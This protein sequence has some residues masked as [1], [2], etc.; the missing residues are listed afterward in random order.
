MEP[1]IQIGPATIQSSILALI[2]ALWL[3]TAIAERE[4]KRR[5]LSGDD[6]WNAVALAGAVTLIAARLVYVLQNIAVYAND[7]RGIFSLTPA[8]LSLGYGALFGLVAAL[9]Y[10]QHRKIPLARFADAF[11]PGA[12]I[13]VAIIACGQFLSG[14]AYGARADLPWAIQLYGVPRQ[15]VQL[16]DALAALIGFVIVWRA[17][18][19]QWVD[20]SIALIAV[21]WYSAA[22]VVIDAF[23]GDATVLAGGYRTTQVI[24]LGV[25]IGA[26]W[27]S[28]RIT[29]ESER[30]RTENKPPSSVIRPPS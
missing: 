10:A 6:A 15:P 25:L 23:R 1:I 29:T 7:W 8:T 14:D 5:G 2:V 13:A 9:A 12:L 17:A 28:S 22:R 24:A 4:G 21:A 16:Y 26:L 20:G 3:G 11:A 30:P 18:R 19:Q 27:L